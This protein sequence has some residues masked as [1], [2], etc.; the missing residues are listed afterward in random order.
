M[1]K[2]QQTPNTIPLSPIGVSFI[3]LLIPLVVSFWSANPFALTK[4]A[5]LRTLVW[6]TAVAHLH[7]KQA[8]PHPTL[9]KSLFLLLS[10]LLTT[11]IAATILATNST[12]SWWGSYTQQQGL[13]TQASYLLLFLIVATTHFTP[14]TLHQLL[15]YMILPSIPISLIGLAQWFGYLHWGLIT[16]ARS[17][18]FT[19]LG[20]ANFTGAYLA[21]VT[22][23]TLAFLWQ[24]TTKSK[25]L[26]YT[27]LL[28]L[29]IT[30]TAL[31]LSRAAL[32]AFILGT[33]TTLF[34]RHYPQLSRP[35]KQ[36]ALLAISLTT[37]LLTLLGT[38]WLFNQ[39]AGSSAART[40]IW[41]TLLP[42]IKENL[43]FGYGFDQIEFI[44]PVHYPPQLVYYQGR[45]ILITRAHNFILE[46]TFATGL[47]SFLLWLTLVGYALSSAI[48]HLSSQHPPSANN[49]FI[50]PLCGLIIAHLTN[51]LFSF[52]TT[53]TAT[54]FW[55]TLALLI[56]LTHPA[57]KS[58]SKPPPPYHQA[59][60]ITLTLL[61]LILAWLANGRYLLADFYTHQA[62]L[63]T[64]VSKAITLNQKAIHYAPHQPVYYHNLSRSY[65]QAATQQPSQA[66]TYFSLATIP[67]QT[68]QEITPQDYRHF[69]TLA[70]LY[71]QWA[72]TI[73]PDYL[74]NADNAFASATTIAPNLATLY[75]AWGEL[76]LN[77][78][79][80]IIAQQKFNQALNL[81]A[82]NP[83]LYTHLGHIALNNEDFTVAFTNFTT[84]LQEQPNHLPA[85]LGLAQLALA[86][87]N[88]S[89]AQHYLTPILQQNPQNPIAQQ[90]WRQ[91]IYP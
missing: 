26:L 68:A 57:T 71:T 31:T 21:L 54:L 69:E 48:K 65:Q 63:A 76:Y 51:N 45:G 5:L 78:N 34:L 36:Y 17:P 22:P 81:D 16:D 88:P 8:P 42:L 15:T 25:R 53:T 14:Q 80:P 73:D 1:I 50:P 3:L 23:I 49:L 11:Q 43:W 72:L 60:T 13:L 35:Q 2:P 64:N 85:Q 91:T 20:R 61:V 24:A 56:T 90:L 4:T 27:L 59:T 70:K 62:H 82:S 67:L 77:I 75:T 58:T 37:A 32:L 40:T 12:I 39:T 9:P 10:F 46:K 33:A 38:I 74:T 29:Q 18:L 28:L 52:E 7:Q 6:L 55:I 84:A 87:N 47:I 66:A 89:L 86:Q 19:T 30:V 44:F 41:R 79:Q 83:M